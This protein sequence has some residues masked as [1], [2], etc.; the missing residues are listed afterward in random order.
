AGRYAPHPGGAAQ[1]THRGRSR[2][3]PAAGHPRPG[4]PH[5]TVPGHRVG[6]GLCPVRPAAAGGRRT[7]DDH[8]PHRAGG[9]DQCAAACPRGPRYRGAHGASGGALGALG[10]QWSPGPPAGAPYRQWPGPDRDAAARRHLR[11]HRASRSTWRRMADAGRL[12]L[13]RDR[14]RPGAPASPTTADGPGRNRGMMTSV[15]LADDQSLLR[16]GFRM[17]LEAEDDIEVV[18]EAADGATAVQ[19]AGSLRPDV[20]LMDVRMP[21]MNGIEA[22][23][24]IVAQEPATKV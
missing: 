8:L 9:A 17:V 16:M 14:G 19:M 10:A 20:V 7:A 15:L 6:G 2:P 3:L 13:H 18:G 11:R 24:Q 5:R 4:G 12:V 21:G 22:T 1:R 23:S